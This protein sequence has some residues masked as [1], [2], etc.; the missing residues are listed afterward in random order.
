VLDVRH[1]RP[2]EFD[3]SSHHA[4]PDGTEAVEAWRCV[5][6][7]TLR[8]PL[9]CAGTLRPSGPSHEPEHLPGLLRYALRG[10]SACSTSGTPPSRDASAFDDIARIRSVETSSAGAVVRALGLSGL[11]D[12]QD[13]YQ[14]SLRSDD[15]LA[16]EVAA[17]FRVS[18]RRLFDVLWYVC[19]SLFAPAH[20]PTNPASGHPTSSGVSPASETTSSTGES[21]SAATH[22]RCAPS[23]ETPDRTEDTG[24]AA[25]PPSSPRYG[26]H[27]SSTSVLLGTTETGSGIGRTESD[28]ILLASWCLFVLSVA[29]RETVAHQWIDINLAGCPVATLDA[30]SG[31]SASSDRPRFNSARLVTAS[32]GAEAAHVTAGFSDTGTA[33]RFF[34]QLDADDPAEV[35]RYVAKPS[36]AEKNAGLSDEHAA[37]PTVKPVALMRW[38]IRLV[39]KPGDVVLDPFGGSG[40]TGVAALAEGRRVILVERDPRFAE[41]ARARLQHAVP[42]RERLAT[43]ATAPVRVEAADYGPL[44]GGAR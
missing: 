42:T 38:L 36:R 31:E 5:G 1:D 27:E 19:S 24:A 8:V 20:S 40:T 17:A 26:T 25:P 35:F 3:P 10:W 30:Q 18:P 44:F 33:A 43:M 21:R 39:T 41:I 13:D 23:G 37:H 2:R 29:S 14:F 9:F 32:K 15:A 12:F 22:P 34:P 7:T 11:R 16:R 4:D 6:P 28:E